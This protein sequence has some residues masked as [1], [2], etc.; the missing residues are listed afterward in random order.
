M[1]TRSLMITS[2]KYKSIGMRS[3]VKRFLFFCVALW[4]ISGSLFGQKPKPNVLLIAIDDLN[5]YVGLLQN[6]P[7][8]KTPNLDRFAKTALNF[9]RA[10][11]AA[12]VCNPSRAALL[13]GVPPY[14]TGVYDNDNR[15]QDSKVILNATFLPEHFKANGYTTLTRGKIF[16][17][18]P[19]KA[20]YEA[21]W[22]ENGGQGD[23]GPYPTERNVP[24]TVRAPLNFNYQPWTGPE[25]DHPDNVTAEL[26]IERL[27][28][29]YDKPFFMACGLYKPH[30]PWTAPRRFFDMYP[31][32]NIVLPK[33]LESDWDDL[34]PIAKKW[35]SNPVDFE[36]LKQSGQWKSVVRSYLACIS[37]MDWNFGRIIDALDKSKYKNNTIICV[38]ADNGFHLGEK[39]HFAKYALWEQTTHILHLWRVPGITKAGK[40]CE[41]P[42]NLLDIFPTL[43]EL[44]RLSS[45]KQ[46]L[47]GRSIVELLKNP[48]ITWDHPSITTYLEGNQSLRTEKYRY[49]LYKDGGEELYDDSADPREW[50]NLAADPRMKDLI[51]SLRKKISK[52][53]AATVSGNNKKGESV[54]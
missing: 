30:N 54:E 4:S 27:N 18:M 19:D 14:R 32:E 46:Q 26:T 48:A 42:V 20:R 39:N 24:T 25:S 16:H 41:R 36:A 10:Y 51:L 28:K 34:P 49:T 7:G 23:Y 53:F 6:F 31:L 38:F 13:S 33:V 5:D 37:F 9:T 47:E 11:C 44:C 29:N 52:E 8:L 15:I 17:T 43:V 21:M 2:N 45:P 22:D 1:R 12:P 3:N 40:I 50:H 35:A